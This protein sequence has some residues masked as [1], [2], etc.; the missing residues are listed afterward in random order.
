MH[1]AKL[2][3][4]HFRKANSSNSFSSKINSA[5]DHILDGSAANPAMLAPATKRLLR[6]NP[7]RTQT[8]ACLSAVLLIPLDRLISI[9]LGPANGMLLFPVYSLLIM[10]ML[11]AFGTSPIGDTT[12]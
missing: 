8:V 9:A 2:W 4:R 5:T 12:T 11:P 3:F 6:S 10:P 7:S 1:G